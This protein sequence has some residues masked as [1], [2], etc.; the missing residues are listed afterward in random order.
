MKISNSHLRKSQKDPGI[1]A[2][3]PCLF[4]KYFLFN[5]SD[6]YEQTKREKKNLYE[7]IYVFISNHSVF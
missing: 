1:E 4:D 3:D 6:Y 5:D 2:F 7:I